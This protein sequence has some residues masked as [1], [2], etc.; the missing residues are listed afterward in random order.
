MCVFRLTEVFVSL[1]RVAQQHSS[2]EEDEVTE[3]DEGWRKSGSTVV[4]LNQLVALELPDG[5]RVVLN[6][7]EGVAVMHNETEFKALKFTA[8]FYNATSTVLYRK[9]FTN[10]KIQPENYEERYTG[11]VSKPSK[12]PT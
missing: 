9:R 4:L 10:D 12:L 1:W 3:E 7:L 2:D 5:V 11:S 6:L 8:I